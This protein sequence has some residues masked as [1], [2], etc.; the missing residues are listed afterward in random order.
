[1]R[2]ADR[3]RP[4]GCA[5]ATRG[6]GGARPRRRLPGCAG[7]GPAGSP[8]SALMPGLAALHSPGTGNLHF[9]AVARAMKASCAA[10]RDVHARP[11]ITA[12]RRERGQAVI[13]HPRVP[14]RGR[15]H[16]VRRAVVGP[17]GCT[18]GAPR[19]RAS[20][21]SADPT[22]GGRHRAARGA[23]QM[24]PVPHRAAVPRRPPDQA[25]R[26]AGHA[27]A[28]RHAGRR[29]DATGALAPVRRTWPCTLG[30]P[31]TWWSPKRF[32]RTGLSELQRRR[33][34]GPPSAPA[35]GTCR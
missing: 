7:S 5:A 22:C 1:M 31:G 4:T 13:A 3:R 9:G 14:T 28:D 15:V 11:P 33:A 26:W 29:R 25:H 19:I 35:R 8:R 10:G 6:A 27:R 23:R 2:K 34:A 17:P 20:P 21:R 16:R 12:V 24:Y 18:A 32:W 30:W